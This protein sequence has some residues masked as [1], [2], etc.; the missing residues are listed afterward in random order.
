MSS[1][2]GKVLMLFKGDYDSSATYAVL[3]VVLYQGLSYVAKQTTTGNA[4]TNTTYWQKLLDFPTQ[5]DNVPTQ[6]SNNL[7]KSGGVYSALDD[8]LDA[9]KGYSTDDSTETIADA[10][11]VPFY[12]SSATAPKKTL[13]SALVSTL[14]AVFTGATSLTAGS[15]GTVPAPSA[16]DEGKFLKGDGTWGNVPKPSVMT[17]ATSSAAGTSGL[18]PAPAAGDNTKFLRGDGTY[19]I[20]SDR[21]YDQTVT[22]STS[23][24]TTVTFTDVTTANLPTNATYYVALSISDMEYSNLD[25]S[26]AGT[27]SLKLPK[28]ET[29]T[30]VSVRLYVKYPTT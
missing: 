6:N 21:Y 18:V 19:A 20:A 7:V 17:G 29:A 5:V 25:C 10:D 11:Y 28:W 27:V 16:G 26:T 1:V 4:P 8:K 14:T 9:S 3:D 24:K 12:D 15:K 2:A 13:W 30:S 22:V 23:A